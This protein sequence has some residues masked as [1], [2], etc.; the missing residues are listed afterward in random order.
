MP[1]MSSRS[2]LDI[3][4]LESLHSKQRSLEESLAHRRQEK[5]RA[6]SIFLEHVRKEMEMLI[7]EQDKMDIRNEQLRRSTNE[8]TKKFSKLLPELMQA[9]DKLKNAK[10]EYL[11][12]LEKNIGD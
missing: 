9:E 2:K 5:E 10:V 6:H 1:E 11:K 8:Y 3:S 4:Y 12:Y 7:G